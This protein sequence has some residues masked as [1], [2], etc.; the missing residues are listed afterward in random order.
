MISSV[1]ISLSAYLENT[2]NVNLSFILVY[3]FE[4]N[5]FLAKLTMY[6]LPKPPSPI[7]LI[8][9]YFPSIFL[10]IK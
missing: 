6:T 10:P 5:S 1:G 8:I 9:S 4:P 7:F 2:L 3:L